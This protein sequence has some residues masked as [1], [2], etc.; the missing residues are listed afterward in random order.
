MLRFGIPLQWVVQLLSHRN[1]LKMSFLEAATNCVFKIVVIIT[2]I[3]MTIIIISVISIST[4]IML[5]RSISTNPSVCSAVAAAG[6]PVPCVVWQGV[7]GACDEMPCGWAEEGC[8][9]D[10]NQRAHGRRL[11]RVHGW[12]QRAVHLP[13]GALWPMSEP[14]RQGLC[15]AVTVTH[16]NLR[17]SG[18]LE[19]SWCPTAAL[20]PE[21]Q[22]ADA[23]AAGRRQLGQQG[24]QQQLGMRNV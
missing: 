21:R 1:D 13:A 11:R 10:A 20:P 19:A 12:H 18:Q 16:G 6:R 7:G 22:A 15:A 9:R 23:C 2:V 3:M 4:M 5:I 17:L 24:M 14:A 8:G